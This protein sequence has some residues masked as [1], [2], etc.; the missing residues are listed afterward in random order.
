MRLRRISIAGYILCIMLILVGCSSE[1]YLGMQLIKSV[2]S[3][4]GEGRIDCYQE[5]G[6]S[7]DAV[8]DIIC[9]F[10]KSNGSREAI[11]QE[12]ECSEVRI[13]WLDEDTVRI[14][15]EELNVATD[16][17]NRDTDDSFGDCNK[18]SDYK[19]LRKAMT[20]GSTKTV[21]SILAAGDIDLEHM[22]VKVDTI[23]GY[24][25]CRALAWIFDDTCYFED[26][27]LF[28]YTEPTD[29]QRKEIARL[30]IQYGADVDSK[31]KG[32]MTYLMSMSADDPEY[33][34]I[35]LN[36]GADAC[37]KDIWGDNVIDYDMKK[38]SD[39]LVTYD[40]N[41]VE[42]YFAEYEKHGLNVSIDNI[43]K[44]LDNPECFNN[45]FLQYMIKKTGV[46]YIELG[47]TEAE[48]Y[49]IT[50]DNDSLL[51]CIRTGGFKKE[52]ESDD[53]LWFAAR[54]CNPEVLNELK[55]QGYDLGT[56]T[57][58]AQSLLHIA[59]KANT[60]EV[61]E[62]LIS[63]GISANTKTLWGYTPLTVATIA[64]RQDIIKVLLKH[65]ALWKRDICGYDSDWFFACT[66]GG[67]KS[68]D[69]LVSLDYQPN[70]NEIGV[71]YQASNDETFL[72]LIKNGVPYNIEY[73]YCSW[74][75][76]KMISVIEGLRESQPEKAEYLEKLDRE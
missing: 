70:D 43:R 4:S 16:H 34:K 72:S 69:T 20:N 2:P 18:T 41:D 33:R 22:S 68:I 3:P 31:G 40:K 47:V 61:I 64:G 36:A 58:S 21:E 49:A 30:L 67:E 65:G 9:Y 53:L 1:N 63:Q 15:H 57:D 14:N 56:T 73:E 29:M 13:M 66:Y 75:E 6:E 32:G 19:Q 62:Y 26:H 12:W 35:L 76:E 48:Y 71:G 38:L 42:E 10:I 46:D 7:T 28:S 39:D 60:S 74:D 52:N 45:D 11:Y 24:N 37:A 8:H 59:A 54:N 25:D 51:K 27:D 23:F 17:Y 44:C 50:G 5:G 55:N